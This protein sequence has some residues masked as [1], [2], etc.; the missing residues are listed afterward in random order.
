MGD[1]FSSVEFDCLYLI[2]HDEFGGGKREVIFVNLDVG[3]G[4]SDT[5][6]FIEDL[7]RHKNFEL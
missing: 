1:S 4:Q 6:V 7:V 5:L 2:E 3:I